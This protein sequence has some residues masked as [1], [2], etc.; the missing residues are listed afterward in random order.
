MDIRR[1]TIY[2]THCV[3]VEGSEMALFFVP[4]RRPINPR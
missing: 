2:S 3:V 1:E 4:L